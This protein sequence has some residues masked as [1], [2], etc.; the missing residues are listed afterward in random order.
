[1]KMSQYLLSKALSL[2]NIYFEYVPFFDANCLKTDS[3][4][5]VQGIHRDRLNAQITAKTDRRPWGDWL[6]WMHL[7]NPSSRIIAFDY[8]SSHIEAGI[9]TI[10][11][12][13]NKALQLLDGLVKLRGKTDLVAVCILSILY[14]IVGVRQRA[15]VA[16]SSIRVV[17]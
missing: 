9:N 8:D 6:H 16:F 2:Y 3:I 10:G 15:D 1:M 13:K 4:V 14:P 12:F 7:E 17:Q 5:A 11:R